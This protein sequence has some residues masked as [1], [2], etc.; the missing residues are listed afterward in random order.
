MSLILTTWAIVR[1]GLTII[2]S[3]E[4]G[5]HVYLLSSSKMQCG[6]QFF[7][8]ALTIDIVLACSCMSFLLTSAL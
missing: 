2:V 8:L 1:V 3:I 5:Y 7:S 6:I 4:N